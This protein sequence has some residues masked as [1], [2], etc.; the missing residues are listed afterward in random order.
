MGDVP[1]PLYKDLRSKTSSMICDREKV[2]LDV[3][4]D[5][6]GAMATLSEKTGDS[7]IESHTQQKR[8]K[9]QLAGRAIAAPRRI[10]Q[11]VRARGMIHCQAD[12]VKRPESFHIVHL[13]E[14][15]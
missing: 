11:F 2:S 7:Q 12:R 6:W 3:T 10:S 5:G 8:Q 9:N 13:I 1:A 4:T 14:L 15:D